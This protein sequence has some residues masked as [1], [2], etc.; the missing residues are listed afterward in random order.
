MTRERHGT[1]STAK[2]KPDKADVSASIEQRDIV[3]AVI[4]QGLRH[5][6]EVASIETNGSLP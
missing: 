3:N 1:R 4:D 6:G 2:R 5:Y